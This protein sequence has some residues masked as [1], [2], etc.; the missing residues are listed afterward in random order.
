MCRALDYKLF[1]T[2]STFFTVAGRVISVRK[3]HSTSPL[4]EEYMSSFN[5]VYLF[6]R[7]FYAHYW[8]WRTLTFQENLFD[9]II[10]IVLVNSFTIHT[11][12][13]TI[14]GLP[15]REYMRLL[16]RDLIKVFDQY[17]VSYWKKVQTRIEP[18]DVWRYVYIPLNTEIFLYQNRSNVDLLFT[19]EQSTV[20]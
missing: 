4:H 14:C 19:T 8:D 13:T 10:Q 12:I 17:R 5:T 3:S 7:L 6:N 11:N 2:H 16:Y 18:W 1:D 15:I 20:R 9:S